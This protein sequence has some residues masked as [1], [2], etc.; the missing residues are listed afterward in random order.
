MI[1]SVAAE[2]GG[3]IFEFIDEKA[4]AHAGDSS[5]L[6]ADRCATERQNISQRKPRNTEGTEMLCLARA[7]PRSLLFPVLCRGP[8]RI[9]AAMR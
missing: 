2:R 7:A 5:S 9:V 8:F 4:A 1:G 3:I 6:I